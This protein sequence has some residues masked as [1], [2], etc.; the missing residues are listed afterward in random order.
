[1]PCGRRS[2][3]NS[4]TSIQKPNTKVQTVI[5]VQLALTGDLAFLFH[6]T[7]AIAIKLLELLTDRNP[8]RCIAAALTKY[9]TQLEA[10]APAIIKDIVGAQLH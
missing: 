3:A 7:Q 4:Y 6:N 10:Y 9:A 5:D 2:S 8:L 1:M